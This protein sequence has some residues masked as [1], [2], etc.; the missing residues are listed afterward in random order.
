MAFF[1]NFS[2]LFSLR[3]ARRRYIFN[4]F[5]NRFIKFTSWKISFL[6]SHFAFFCFYKSSLLVLFSFVP[7]A[8]FSFKLNNGGMIKCRNCRQII[9][10]SSRKIAIG[11]FMPAKFIKNHRSAMSSG[12]MMINKCIFSIFFFHK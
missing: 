1:K 12:N 2:W 4:N 10:I 5:S 7:S 8:S 6:P 11:Y 3:A 9:I